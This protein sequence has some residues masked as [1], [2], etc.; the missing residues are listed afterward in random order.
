MLS[1]V[2]FGLDHLE[3][4]EQSA[5]EALQRNPGLASAYLAL[6]DVHGR[7]KE[8]TLQLHDLDAYLKLAPDGPDRRL[9]RQSREVIQRKVAATKERD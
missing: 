3:E 4:A 9:V 8:Y 1:I 5:R 7:R 6:A 2:F